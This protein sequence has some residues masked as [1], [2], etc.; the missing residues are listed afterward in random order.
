LIDSDLSNGSGKQ[1]NVG[2]HAR[3]EISVYRS[4]SL[5]GG[6]SQPELSDKK[7]PRRGWLVALRIRMKFCIPMNPFAMKIPCGAPRNRRVT[8][9]HFSGGF[10]VSGGSQN[11]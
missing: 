3:N 6:V 5:F 2:K 7:G 4:G 10:S 9:K 8:A 11:Q 1:R